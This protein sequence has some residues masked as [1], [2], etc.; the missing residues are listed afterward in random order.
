[1][2]QPVMAQPQMVMAQPQQM[3]SP[4]G[5]VVQIQPGVVQGTK[6]W[7][8]GLFGCFEDMKSCKC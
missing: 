2:A 8:S 5:M 4:Q 6:D 3:V 7:N 1:M